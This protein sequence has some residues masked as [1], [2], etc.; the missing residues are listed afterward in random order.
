MRRL[1]EIAKSVRWYVES[2]MGDNAYS[3]YVA[4]HTDHYPDMPLPS[5]K[6]YWRIRH[7]EAEANPKTRCC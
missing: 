5:E 2:V 6:E 1:R 7:A 4:F 3:K